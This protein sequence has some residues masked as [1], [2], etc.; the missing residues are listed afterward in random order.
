MSQNNCQGGKNCEDSMK[1]ICMMK[2]ASVWVLGLG[3][4]LNNKA[5]HRRLIKGYIKSIENQNEVVS[6]STS[7]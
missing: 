5:L 1:P 2:N 6:E 3:N 7:K 4:I